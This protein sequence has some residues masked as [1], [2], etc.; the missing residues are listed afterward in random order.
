[1]V[2]ATL[3]GDFLGEAPSLVIPGSAVADSAQVREFLRHYGV[4]SIVAQHI[5]ADPDAAY[6]LLESALGVVPV[7]EGGVDEWFHVQGDLR[8]VKA[9]GA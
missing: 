2:P 5:G 7:H 3:V 9:A 6:Q 8:S 1:M 4:Q